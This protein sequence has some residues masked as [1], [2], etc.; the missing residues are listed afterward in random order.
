M[1][2]LSDS[3]KLAFL[4][5]IIKNK[6]VGNG[7]I[8]KKIDQTVH[9]LKNEYGDNLMNKILKVFKNPDENLYLR[10]ENTVL[11]IT[12]ILKQKY[13][14]HNDIIFNRIS[15][16]RLV[17]ICNFFL[18]N[19]TVDDGTIPCLH[20]VEDAEINTLVQ[21]VR[22]VSL[23]GNQDVVK[24]IEK[25]NNNV[26]KQLK[27]VG[28]TVESEITKLKTELSS[29][30]KEVQDEQSD[31]KKEAKDI[32]ELLKQL[33][34]KNNP[35]PIKNQQKATPM[36]QPKQKQSESRAPKSVFAN[37]NIAKVIKKGIYWII[38]FKDGSTQTVKEN[39]LRNKEDRDKINKSRN[40]KK[41][42]NTTTQPVITPVISSFSDYSDDFEPA[43][44]DVDE[45]KKKEETDNNSGDFSS[46]S[47]KKN[48]KR[49]TAPPVP[50]TERR[51]ERDPNSNSGTSTLTPTRLFDTNSNDDNAS[52]SDNFE[53]ESI[54]EENE[55]LKVIFNELGMKG[56][57]IV[58][59]AGIKY[60]YNG[61]KIN[62]ALYKKNYSLF[63][64][65]WR[66][67]DIGVE[68]KDKAIIKDLFANCHEIDFDH[69][70]LCLVGKEL[71][72][73]WISYVRLAMYEKYIMIHFFTNFEEYDIIDC[74]VEAMRNFIYDY[75][76]LSTFMFENAVQ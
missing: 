56:S 27:G 46:P 24:A 39:Q 72:L 64:Q 11:P 22:N 5:N 33:A 15:Y 58:T 32:V 48:I 52:Y 73:K 37:K 13:L 18:Q 61:L 45:T 4:S 17:T 59:D 63:F 23:S 28:M 68:E 36:K 60:L 20:N 41:T 21:Q 16:M 65:R 10:Q 67:E 62:K 76:Y 75:C 3:Y 66:I 71:K 47:K 26:E 6:I 50:P 8:P 38:T 69:D 12:S 57:C 34:E 30:K 53:T 9:L 25:M 19:N 44:V 40:K 74:V 14:Q 51:G 42:D 55:F 7:S 49:K 2:T 43:G 31:L 54:D 1:T 35:L 29:I 70:Y